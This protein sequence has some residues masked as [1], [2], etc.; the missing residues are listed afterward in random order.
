MGFSWGAPLGSVHVER[1]GREQDCT[2]EALMQALRP[3][4]Q[5]YSEFSSWGDPS[6]LPLVGRWG[7]S[8][9]LH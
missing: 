6:E 8:I 2:E 7:L 1:K 5:L 9:S 4:D 3:L